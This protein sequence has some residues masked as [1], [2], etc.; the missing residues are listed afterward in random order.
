MKG[1]VSNALAQVRRPAP[2]RVYLNPNAISSDVKNT[3]SFRP[4]KVKSGDYIVLYTRKG[5]SSTTKNND[6]STTHF[7]FWGLDK[8]IWNKPTDCAVVF[9]LNTWQTSKYESS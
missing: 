7:L 3:H 4:Y 1:I 2:E 6:G 9:E 5:T 8:T